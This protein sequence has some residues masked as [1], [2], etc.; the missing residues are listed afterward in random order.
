MTTSVFGQAEIVVAFDQS[1]LP[2]VCRIVL[3]NSLLPICRRDKNPGLSELET[4][5]VKMVTF[6]TSESAAPY[7][8]N[9]VT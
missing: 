1:F 4:A 3:E 9:N 7:R 2:R 5:A 8:A 6:S